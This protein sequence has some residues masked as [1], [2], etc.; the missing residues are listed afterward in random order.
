MLASNHASL[1]HMESLYIFNICTTSALGAFNVN[2]NIYRPKPSMSSND[3]RLIAL[4]EHLLS[5]ADGS[6]RPTNLEERSIALTDKEAH[7]L[8]SRIDDFLEGKEFWQKAAIV[9]ALSSGNSDRAREPYLA[10]RSA[11]GASRVMSGRHYQD[12]LVRLGQSS[13]FSPDVR[14]MEFEHFL[15]MELRLFENLDLSPRSLA[16]LQRFLRLHEAEIELARSGKKPLTSGAIIS[17]VKGLR[18]KF[19][20]RGE[21]MD[22]YWTT[23][24]AVGALT[25]I[26]NSSVMFGTRDW[27]VA[28]VISAMA[29]AIGLLFV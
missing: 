25:L 6:E 3:R 18:P 24:R 21:L 27:N 9:E 29:G 2:S 15:R 22:T 26:S 5:G 12:F 19:D 13:A 7:E 10:A 1:Q 4:L 14:K 16:M 8:A 20:A 17:A 28:G 23:N 11:R